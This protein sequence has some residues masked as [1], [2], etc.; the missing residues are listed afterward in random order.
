MEG[1]GRRREFSL[2]FLF[3]GDGGD[4]AENCGLTVCRVV[5]SCILLGGEMRRRSEVD[6]GHVISRCKLSSD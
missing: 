5:R 2:V 1:R 4:V 6:W 3:E